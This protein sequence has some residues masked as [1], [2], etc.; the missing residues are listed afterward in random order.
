M[1]LSLYSLLLL[2]LIIAWNYNGI[3][4]K[5]YNIVLF[6]IIT[7]LILLI[8]VITRDGSRLLD[9]DGYVKMFN[10]PYIRPVEKSFVVITEFIK[11]F[12]SLPIWL[13][14]TYALI[15]VSLKYFAI[16]R[17]SPF[18]FYSLAVWCGSFLLLQ[19]MIQIRGAVA[20]S[21]LLCLIPLLYDKKYLISIVV[22]LIAAW[23]HRSALSFVILL[24]INPIN[25][26]WRMWI[27]LYIVMAIINIL[28]L[29]IFQ[30]LGLNDILSA[31]KIIEGDHYD[32]GKKTD[33]LSL[34]AP[35]ILLQTITC[36]VCMYNSE[37]IKNSYPY[38]IICIK[39]CFIGI[40]FYSL[41]MGVISLRIA[42]LF[43]TVFIFTYPLLLY[44]FK[45]RDIRFAKICVSIIC[46]MI[47]SN[48]IFLKGFIR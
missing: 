22:I 35:Y 16:Y 4:K 23:F 29:N 32:M 18:I 2:I 37:K 43:S 10:N 47:L 31:V 39:I 46:I 48:F 12:S 25:S 9:Y 6:S 27:L 30:M 5:R 15:S 20:G 19:E 36:F 7:L 8:I 38:G 14:T 26:R 44:C 17:Y 13:F 41:P 28:D 1:I 24:F 33:N 42:E 45:K 40:L 3:K 11:N 21:L 34:F